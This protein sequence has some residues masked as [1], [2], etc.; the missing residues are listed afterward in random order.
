MYT[1][2]TYVYIYMCIYIIYIYIC[3]YI[4]V[5]IQYICIYIYMCIYTYSK[6]V[7]RQP[8][9]SGRVEPLQILKSPLFPFSLSLSSLLFSSKPRSPQVEVYL[10]PYNPPGHQ[11]ADSVSTGV[12]RVRSPSAY[13]I[14]PCSP[15]DASRHFNARTAPPSCFERRAAPFTENNLVAARKVH[16]G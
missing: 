6:H 13:G 5:Y 7:V 9:G 8:I 3:I 10:P 14:Q 16:A 2:N 1:Y 4:Y 11:L 15:E 12:W